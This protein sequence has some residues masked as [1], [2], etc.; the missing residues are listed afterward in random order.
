M[1]LVIVMAVISIISIYA[2]M[3]TAP[4]AEVTLPSQAQQMASDIRH[5]Q[6]LAYTWGKRMRLT[7]TTG[8]NGTYSV[9][10]FAGTPA[11]DTSNNFSVT[12]Q[13]GVALGG[14]VATGDGTLSFNSLG[15]PLDSLG[16]SASVSYTLTSGGGTATVCVAALTGFVKVAPPDTCP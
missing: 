2:I 8:V 3:K 10:C 16:A 7:V 13:K 11:C 5:A 9:A 15:Q 4:I 14:A 6:T 1:E 12:L